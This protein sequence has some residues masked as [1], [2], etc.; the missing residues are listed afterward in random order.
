MTFLEVQLERITSACMTVQG[1][2]DRI[3][4][5]QSQVNNNDEKLIN[6]T[7]LLKLQQKS[8]D[9]QEEELS[10]LKTIAPISTQIPSEDYV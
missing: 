8:T 6:I 3:E 10:K 4:Q 9:T 1:Y 5:I 7:K 2:A